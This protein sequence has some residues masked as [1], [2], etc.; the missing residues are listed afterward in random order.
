MEIK[1]TADWI[2]ETFGQDADL[3]DGQDVVVYVREIVESHF[4]KLTLD[5]MGI[6]YDF[7]VRDCE[8]NDDKTVS[9]FRF[10]LEDIKKHCPK[11]HESILK[12]CVRN[13]KNTNDEASGTG[14]VKKVFNPTLIQFMDA[15]LHTAEKFLDALKDH[16]ISNEHVSILMEHHEGLTENQLLCYDNTNKV[17]LIHDKESGEYYR[18]DLK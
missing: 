3:Y 6:D 18:I 8:I 4:V 1:L 2:L 5:T 16:G 17:P 14:S 13:K 15:H 11:K 10:K 12:Y 9:E 7:S